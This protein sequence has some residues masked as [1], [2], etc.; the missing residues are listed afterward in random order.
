MDDFR[1]REAIAGGSVAVAT[2]TDD[3]VFI[4][5]KGHFLA[6]KLFGEEL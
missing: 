5:G 1:I 6:K 3:A 2:L 4:N